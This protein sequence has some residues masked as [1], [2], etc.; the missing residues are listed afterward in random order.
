M[1]SQALVNFWRK[2]LMVLMFLDAVLVGTLLILPDTSRAQVTI[3]HPIDPAPM[4]AAQSDE[5]VFA[6]PECQLGVVLSSNLPACKREDKTLT[7]AFK[8]QEDEFPIIE[9]QQSPAQAVFLARNYNFGGLNKLKLSIWDRQQ[10]DFSQIY[11]L[12]ELAEELA[13]GAAS[14]VRFVPDASKA[15]T[16]PSFPL[17][18]QLEYTRPYD[19]FGRS[20]INNLPAVI[21]QLKAKNHL[22]S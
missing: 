4:V 14:R 3:Y 8:L 2:C 10:Q 12:E 18:L 13:A 15:A 22:H 9:V 7:F 1:P 17:R 5:Y 21:L 11:Q 6:L 19:L 20:G 16:M